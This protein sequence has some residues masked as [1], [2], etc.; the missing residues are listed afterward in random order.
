[1]TL[2]E[3]IE[4][5]FVEFVGKIKWK[6]TDPVT[7]SEKEEVRKL[8]T[9]NYYIILTRNNNHISTYFISLGDFLLGRGWSYW[10]HALMNM[11]DEVKDDND[12]RLIESTAKGVHLSTF[13]DVFAVN[14]VAILK[15]KNMKAEDWTAVFEQALSDVGKPYDNLLQIDQTN[16][17]SCVELIRN[18][19]MADADYMTNF[20]NFEAMVQ[21]YKRITPQMFYDCEDFE[22]VYEVRH[23]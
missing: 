22:V 10:G 4:S 7:D 12:F 18:A 8:L 17:F 14:S 19:L 1:M 15:P 20:P 16:S 6:L 2:L 5:A 23:K 11:E 21:K 13:D 3:K 9:P